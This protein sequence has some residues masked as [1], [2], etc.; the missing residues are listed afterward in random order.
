[1]STLPLLYRK[2]PASQNDPGKA[3]IP[4]P[5]FYSP[6]HKAL[7]SLDPLPA[8]TIMPDAVSA[9][10]PTVFLLFCKN[11]LCSPGPTPSSML[12]FLPGMLVSSLSPRQLLIL[13]QVYHP[14]KPPVSLSK[15]S[16]SQRVNSWLL[17]DPAPSKY[18]AGFTKLV[19][20]CYLSFECELF[21]G[22][23]HVVFHL[24]ILAPSPASN[25]KWVFLD[26]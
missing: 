15:L 8:T 22:K 19:S 4:Q 12:F 14:W 17:H 3:W 16:P 18:L 23:G 1:M 26:R 7:Q 10:A 11:T 13:L 24:R 5:G 21:Q 20:M 2:P 9:S 25:T 6:A